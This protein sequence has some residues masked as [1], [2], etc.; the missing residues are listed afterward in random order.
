MAPAND[1]CRYTVKA[2]GYALAAAGSHES[3]PGLALAVGKIIRQ[4][5]LYIAKLLPQIALEL[6]DDGTEKRIDAAVH[7]GQRHL[8][9]EGLV[10]DSESVVKN[11]G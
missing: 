11:L 2:G 10:S 5:R 4:P 8:V 1:R 3:A 7:L 6:E 9:I